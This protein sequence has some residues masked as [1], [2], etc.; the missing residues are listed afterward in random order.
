MAK[1]FDG[2]VYSDLADINVAS[3]S[4]LDA[5]S[6][7]LKQDG[8]RDQGFRFTRIEWE[9][10]LRNAVNDE[11]PF[12]VYIG[13][14]GMSAADLELAIEADPQ[15]PNQLA[16][17]EQAMRIYFFLGRVTS[18]ALEANAVSGVLKPMW[19]YPESDAMLVIAYNAGTVSSAGSQLINYHAKNYG[20][21][22]R[23]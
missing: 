7:A 19:S 2:F 6:A 18:L 4:A 8:S 15:S 11:G 22:L 1:H 21:W 5:V 10:S 20:V 3:L 9:L 13:G 16:A 14:P 23:D 17:A 12:D